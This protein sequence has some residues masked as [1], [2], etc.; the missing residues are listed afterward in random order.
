MKTKAQK[1]LNEIGNNIS[2]ES[3]EAI[4][5]IDRLEHKV[6]ELEEKL[7]EMPVPEQ[8]PNPVVAKEQKNGGKD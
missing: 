5:S 6:A 7:A 1:I 2:S 4:L 8:Q 3:R